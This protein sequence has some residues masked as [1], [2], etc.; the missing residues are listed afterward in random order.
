MPARALP[1]RV[2][3]AAGALALQPCAAH[4][5][6]ADTQFWLTA[7]ARVT[8]QDD[9][10]STVMAS[11]RFRDDGRGGDYQL[12]R[13]TL[14]W[15]ASDTLSIGGGLTYLELRSGHEW[16]T[17]QQL[18]LSHGPLALRT[19][20][21]ERFA[22]GTDR[23]QIRLRER[24]QGTFPIGRRDKLVVNGELLYILQPELRSQHAR[25]D[26]LRFSAALLHSLNHRLDLSLG[27]MAILAPLAGH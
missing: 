7:V 1:L 21:E 17:H 4:A 25:V 8:L 6:D 2:C 9:L 23:S 20:L 12:G 27:Y 16:R 3:L 18:V 14:D 5:A 24:L 19:Q 26:S 22:A 11:Q 15:Q 10:S 13:A